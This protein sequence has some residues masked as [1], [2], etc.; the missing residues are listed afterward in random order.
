MTSPMTSFDKLSILVDYQTYQLWW[1]SDAN[2]LSYCT[3]KFE[4]YLILAETG[5][6]WRHWWRHHDGIQNS[7][8]ILIDYQSYQVWWTSD[9]NFLSYCIQKLAVCKIRAKNGQLWRHS[10]Q[11]VNT[12]WLSIISSLVNITHQMETYSFTVY[13]EPDG[14]RR[15]ST[16]FV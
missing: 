5:Q 7:L 4:I 3:H 9:A 6:L 10:T 1:T 14:F 16:P 13:I 12:S 2:L 11:F 15:V 8:S